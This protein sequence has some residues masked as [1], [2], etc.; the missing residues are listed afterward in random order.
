MCPAAKLR[1]KFCADNSHDKPQAWYIPCK[2]SRHTILDCTVADARIAMWVVLRVRRDQEC[3]IGWPIL[4]F[5][6]QSKSMLVVLYFLCCLCNMKLNIWYCLYNLLQKSN[7]F[8]ALFPSFSNLLIYQKESPA[9]LPNHVL[10]HKATK[11]RTWFL[12]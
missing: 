6:I 3:F 10:H 2:D 8:V 11:N 1:R 5:V 9:N 4:N 12:K 7:L